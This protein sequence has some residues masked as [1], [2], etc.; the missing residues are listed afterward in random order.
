MQK[1]RRHCQG[2][3][4]VHVVQVGVPM[5]LPATPS[6]YVASG[7]T[8]GGGQGGTLPKSFPQSGAGSFSSWKKS[9]LCLKAQG[10]MFATVLHAPLAPAL[11]FE[12]FLIAPARATVMAGL[13][14]STLGP[15]ESHLGPWA[16]TAVWFTL[17]PYQQ[18]SVAY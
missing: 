2:H 11:G 4:A 5:S 15:W 16:E 13:T 14:A 17:T 8:R 7:E 10:R 3:L 9:H 6:A 18:Q 1:L 12:Q